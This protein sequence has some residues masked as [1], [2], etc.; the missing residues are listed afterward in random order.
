M[1][2]T[3]I[4]SI[5]VSAVQWLPPTIYAKGEFS[6]VGEHSHKDKAIQIKITISVFEK[7]HT[8][9]TKCQHDYLNY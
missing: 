2:Q 6:N 1:S 9:L 3:E 5:L 4:A 8:E 7:S